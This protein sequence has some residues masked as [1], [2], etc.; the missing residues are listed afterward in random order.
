M[1]TNEKMVNGWGVYRTTND[2]NDNPRYIISWKALADSYEEA[3]KVAKKFG[4]KA[5]R[6]KYFGGAIVFRSYNIEET[7]GEYIKK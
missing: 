7:I 2:V 6:V 3:L 4:G 1:V 5:Y